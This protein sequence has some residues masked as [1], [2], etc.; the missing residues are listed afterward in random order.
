MDNDVLLDS[1]AAAGRTH[2]P[3]EFA[4]LGD[5]PAGERLHIT[6]YLMS[7]LQMVRNAPQTADRSMIRSESKAALRCPYAEK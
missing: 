3:F 5:A 7:F 6:K 1:S 2:V 4:R